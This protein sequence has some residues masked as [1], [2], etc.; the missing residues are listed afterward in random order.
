MK[1]FFK[2]NCL[3]ITLSLLIFLSFTTA[4]GSE[5]SFFESSNNIL[6]SPLDFQI[7]NSKET[8]KIN[9]ENSSDTKTNINVENND[10]FSCFYSANHPHKKVAYLTFDDGPSKNTVEIL[11]ILDKYNVKATFFVT[12]SLAKNNPQLYKTI[13]QKGHAIG[14]HSY[15]HE[16]SEIYQSPDA[17]IKDF[18]KLE[19]YLNNKVGINTK[20]ARLPGGSNNTISNKYGGKNIMVSISKY[21]INNNYTYFD[22]NVDS[23]DASVPVQ[24]KDKIVKSVLD[25]SKNKT[26]VII[27]MHDSSA[28][29]TT[30]KALP[31]I[32]EGLSKQ[33]FEFRSLSS[34]E[35]VTQFLRA[36]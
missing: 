16:Y 31:E 13:S 22:W 11:K 7:G 26:A 24:S 4:Y 20:I 3:L 6:L 21:L 27:L 8:L 36:K 5:E 10:A 23:T 2:N 14:N 29:T 9:T 34:E 18:N 12:G 35:Y 1:S 32:I 30:V 15:S 25:E 17:F 19:N 33:H 28:K